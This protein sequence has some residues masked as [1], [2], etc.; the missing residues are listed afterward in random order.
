MLV[1]ETPRARVRKWPRPPAA[2]MAVLLATLIL[3]ACNAAGEQVPAPGDPGGTT[4]GTGTH[5]VGLAPGSI[6]QDD[7]DAAAKA[8]PFATKLTVQVLLTR[9]RLNFSMHLLTGFL[10]T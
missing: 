5:L 4:T 1:N 6:T 3:A 10:G 8:E 9:L 2:V 7:Y